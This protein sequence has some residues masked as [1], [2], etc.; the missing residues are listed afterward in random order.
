MQCSLTRGAFVT[1]I[2]AAMMLFTAVS[3]ADETAAIKVVERPGQLEIRIAG[4][5]FATYVYRDEKTLRPYFSNVRSPAGIQVTRHHPPRPD[6]D[7]TDHAELHPGIWLAFGDIN[8]ADFWRNKGR[9]EHVEFVEKPTVDGGKLIFAVRNRYIGGEK[10]ICSELCRHTIAMRPAGYLLLYDSEF[11]SNAPFAFGDQEEFGL[12]FR[13]AS[14]LRVKGGNGRMLASDG[15]Q[16]EKEVRGSTADWVDYSGEIDGQRVGL[17]LMPDPRNFR[18]SWYHARDYGFIAANPF[19]RNALT[20]GPKSS[21]TVKPGEKF[22]LRFGVLIHSSPA[23]QPIN[24][25]AA[26]ADYLEQSK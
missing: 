5:P 4:K 21:V 8:G 3:L 23:D 24:L 2:C 19:G 10:T 25:K 17:T 7:P 15:K 16:N 13:V 1:A 11:S 18:R 14:P 9:V 20:G 12:G 22:R 26:Y 6:V